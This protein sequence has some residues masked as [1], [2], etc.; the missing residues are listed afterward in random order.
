[1]EIAGWAKTKLRELNADKRVRFELTAWAQ[2]EKA[3]EK[4]KK[5]KGRPKKLAAVREQYAGIIEKYPGTRAAVEARRRLR[6]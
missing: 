5:A 2:L 1:M 3:I 4:E 6:K